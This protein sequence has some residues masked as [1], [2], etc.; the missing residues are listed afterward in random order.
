MSGISK[1]CTSFSSCVGWVKGSWCEKCC[2]FFVLNLYLIIK[3]VFKDKRRPFLA[4]KDYW[5]VC[6]VFG[7]VEGEMAG[8]LVVCEWYG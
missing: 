4:N 5:V 1:K 6:P 7:W 8:V 3:N 2:G